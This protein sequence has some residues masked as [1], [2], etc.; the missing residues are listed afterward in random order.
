MRPAIPAEASFLNIGLPS[1]GGS[2]RF[3]FD[4]PAKNLAHFFRR[5]FDWAGVVD[6]EVCRV[7]FTF[8]R[9]LSG[10]TPPEF[11]DRPAAIAGDSCLA[12]RSGSVDEYQSVT[13]RVPAGF[14]QQGRVQND[15]VHIV[16]RR[17]NLLFNSL[18]NSRVKDAFK[19]T[20]SGLLFVGRPEDKL[21]QPSSY[22]GAVFVDNFGTKVVLDLEGNPRVQQ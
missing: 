12:N 15:D 17:F 11:V 20:F 7:T 18:A 8:D 6:D 21:C 19:V 9:E 5:G 10:F 22:D 14:Q 16:R 4:N 13:N 2:C 3:S 1:I